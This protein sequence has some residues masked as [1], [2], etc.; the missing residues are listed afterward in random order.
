MKT[1]S[2]QDYKKAFE[3]LQ[4]K[5]VQ[6][7][8][9]MSK[10]EQAWE[11][12]QMIEP[13]DAWQRCT[14]SETSDHAQAV[15]DAI[16]Y[17]PGRTFKN[18]RY[19]VEVRNVGDGA[20]YLSIKRNDKDAIGKERFRDFQRIKNELVSEEAEGVEIYPAE[21]RL[22]DASNQYHLW[23]FDEPLLFGFRERLIVKGHNENEPVPMESR[24]RGFD[25]DPP[26]AITI[27][28]AMERELEAIADDVTKD[29]CTVCNGKGF[30]GRDECD[31]CGGHCVEPKL[32]GCVE[33]ELSG[34]TDDVT[35]CEFC[36]LSVGCDCAVFGST[37]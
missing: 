33:Q 25:I 35:R 34:D 30:V 36:Q 8:D 22:V 2:K 29:W 28:E 9:R 19:T 21:S 14:H 23:C 5:Y 7:V 3:A 17:E 26:D 32:G 6:C 37:T 15:L 4:K 1:P 10:A 20:T 24:Q 18:S 16:D 27:E 12:S 31:H 13:F 11:L